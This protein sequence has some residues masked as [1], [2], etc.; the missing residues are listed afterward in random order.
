MAWYNTDEEGSGPYNT[1]T[2]TT[3][4]DEILGSIEFIVNQEIQIVEI[5]YRE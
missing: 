1:A 3:I 4:A 2:F 5:F